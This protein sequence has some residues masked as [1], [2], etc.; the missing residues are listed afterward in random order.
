VKKEDRGNYICEASNGIGS[1]V[2]NTVLL[3][4]SFAPILS[5]KRPK[6]GQKEGY[7]AQ[8][9]CKSTSYPPAAVSFIHKDKELLN[10]EHYKIDYLGRGNEQTEVVLTLHEVKKHHYGE[11]LCKA[12]NPFGTDETRIELFGKEVINFSSLLFLSLAL[13]NY[14]LFLF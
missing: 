4:V 13:L 14:F 8:L 1:T 3:E 5:A 2:N 9:I 12:K 10:N 11:Y 6:V 7:Q